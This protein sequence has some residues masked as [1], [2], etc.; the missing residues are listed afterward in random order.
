[1]PEMHFHLRWPDGS[2]ARCYSPSL[3]VK[4]YLEPGRSYPLP[5]FLQR[6]REALNIAS[7]R[8]RA[9]Y[10]FACSAAMDQLQRIEATA[11][12]FGGNGEV[13]VTAFEE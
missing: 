11:A 8:V 7:E 1:M 10:G 5:D 6:S 12:T 3:V 2:S 9:K 13:A 4:D